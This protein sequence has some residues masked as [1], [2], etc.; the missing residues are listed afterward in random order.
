MGPQAHYNLFS[1]EA[2]QGLSD[3]FFAEV[4]QERSNR[5]WCA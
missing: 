1:K 5:A 2:H 4:K 3:P